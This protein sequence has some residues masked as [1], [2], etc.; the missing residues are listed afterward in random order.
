MSMETC[1]R[2]GFILARAGGLGLCIS[3]AEHPPA[4]LPEIPLGSMPGDETPAKAPIMLDHRSL[5][6]ASGAA[7]AGLLV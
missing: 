2:C 7:L 6:L 1:S 4:G 5:M 3:G